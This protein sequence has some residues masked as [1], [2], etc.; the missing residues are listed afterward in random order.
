MAK[1]KY[2]RK[3]EFRMDINPDHVDSKGQPH[4]AFISVRYGHKYKAN[5]ITHSRT[6]KGI[7]NFNIAENP[8]KRSNDKR[9][10]RISPP[11]WQNDNLFDSEK[12]DNFRFSNKT[13]KYIKK[14]N[15][16][17]K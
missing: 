17:Y 3:N 6:S 13:Q 9:Q 2:L 5:T 15:K 11:F 8:D 16:K 1:K 7:P 10:T 12:L 4:P 14:I